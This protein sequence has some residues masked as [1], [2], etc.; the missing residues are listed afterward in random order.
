MFS[1]PVGAFAETFVV[2]LGERDLGTMTF[3]RDGDAMRLRVS[4]N[5]TPLNLFD[6]TLDAS[7]RP[8]RMANG[9]IRRQLLALSDTTRKNREISV[10]FDGDV[11]TDVVV[12]PAS[13]KTP[14]SVAEN[15]PIA[16]IDPVRAFGQIVS[17]QQCPGLMQIYDGRRAVRLTTMQ[18]TLSGDIVRCDVA[19][20]VI[21]G[22]GHLSP[23]SFK[24]ATVALFYD[25]QRFANLT[26][27]AGPFSITFVRSP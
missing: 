26:V 14:L 17:G 21:A 9:D 22:P 24:N 1:V 12:N 19:Y 16:V 3:Q 15:V 20:R 11:V 23:L 27:T 10:I 8:V 7:S 2:R 25:A 4:L 13:E 6:G 18:S 5:N